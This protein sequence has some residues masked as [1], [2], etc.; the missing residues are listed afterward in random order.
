M[1]TIVGTVAQHSQRSLAEATM[2]AFDTADRVRVDA[3]TRTAMGEDRVTRS[4]CSSRE[5]V[6]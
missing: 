5:N 2:D 6:S 3:K 1:T 4:A